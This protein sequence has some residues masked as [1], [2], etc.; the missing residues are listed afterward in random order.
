MS[1]TLALTGLSGTGSGGTLT[2]GATLALVGL[3]ATGSSGT[4]TAV[5]TPGVDPAYWRGTPWIGHPKVA[6]PV[7]GALR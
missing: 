3:A 4:L 2:A 5:V 7:D 6:W 1:S